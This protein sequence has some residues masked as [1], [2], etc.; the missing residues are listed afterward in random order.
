[1]AESRVFLL[2]PARTDGRRAKV[3]LNPK[4]EFDLAV[5]LREPDGVELGEVFS[6]LSGL[7]FRGKLTYSRA[8]APSVEQRPSI[9]VI[10]ADRGL[11]PP[12]RRVTLEDLQQFSRVDIATGD[13]RYLTPL[14]RDTTALSTS[15]PSDA[16]VVLLGSIATGKYADVLLTVFG[17]RLVFPIDFVGRGDMSRGGLLLRSAQDGKELEYAPVQG[18]QRRGSRPPRLE[19]LR[20]TRKG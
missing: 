4:A 7:Y 15:L 18:A 19:P 8:F 11:V 13:D 14:R 9:L 16:R 5:R 20:R 2:S 1:M 17:E 12:E 10:T 6:F 3:L